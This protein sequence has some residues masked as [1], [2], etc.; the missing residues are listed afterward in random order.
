MESVQEKK[1]IDLK[2]IWQAIFDHRKVFYW[3]IPITFVISSA[4]I[5]CVPRYFTC[6]VTLA[7]E[8]QN[9]IANGSLGSL[10][11]SFG[12]N[13]GGGMSEDAIYPTLYPDVVKSTD[14]MAGLFDVHVTTCNH[15]F[16]GTYYDYLA[17]YNRYPFWKAAKRA[18]K[19]SI[20]KFKPKSPYSKPSEITKENNTFWF[21][22]R[23]TDIIT[24]MR[25]NIT[26]NVD[27]RTDVITLSVTAQD[28]LVAAT[29]ADSV[30]QHLQAFMTT[31]RTQKARADMEYYSLLM[32]ETYKDYLQAR[33]N[34]V[35][36][37]DSH[38][39]LHRE[40]YRIEANYLEEEMNLHYA[41]YSTY[42]KQ[43]L[44]AQTKLRDNTPV[45]TILQAA[46][47]PNMPAGPKRVAFV[48]LMC[49]V[50]TITLMLWFAKDEII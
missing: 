43:C 19:R 11:S 29:M 36:Y 20:S 44:A 16:D 17:T 3:A 24:L 13:I 49:F 46:V 21:D 27:K 39:D 6:R 32:Q 23:Q 8:V 14:F 22:S 38:T 40:A 18:V 15:A 10:A 34:F 12:F 9:A 50:V 33:L 30:R 28:P 25:K 37:C 47:V 1:I 42:Q 45:Y 7:P 4:L 48:L 2:R 41:A 31:Y 5:L 26:C 35:N